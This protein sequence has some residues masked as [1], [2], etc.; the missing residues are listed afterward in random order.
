MA[1][2]V[3]ACRARV[4]PESGQG[5]ASGG[6][7]ADSAA[8][9]TVSAAL[10]P[11]AP[12]VEP[13]TDA[14]VPPVVR[15]SELE[16][17][18]PPDACPPTMAFLA[19]GD[20]WMG[21]PRGRRV[22]DEQ[23]RFS[24][25]VASFCLDTYEVTAASYAQCVERGECS[26]PHGSQS[27]CN[28]GR[29]ED[30]PVNCVDW[31][32]AAAYCKSQGSRLP[33]EL[34]WEY[35]ARGGT[36]YYPYAWGAE[37]PDQRACWKTNQT[38]PV[39]SYPPGAFGLR[40]LSGNVWEWTNDWYGEYPWPQLDGSAKVFRGGGWGRRRESSLSSTLRGRMHPRDWGSHLGFRCARLAQGAECPFGPGDAPGLCR[41][42]VLEAECASD[43]QRFNGQRCTSVGAA[44]CASGQELVSGHGCVP[45]AGAAAA[46]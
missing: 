9:A 1:S 30:H 13:A 12:S 19:G 26:V 32:Q 2:A 16:T 33:S 39:G 17:A 6:P 46:R 40:D 23:P 31:Q 28:Y 38:C 41:H 42:G 20:F 7:Q 29:R 4:E 21:S 45:R 36:R 44:A 27:S 3:A 11:D 37:P 22:S 34:E 35:A 5:G 8:L 43:S 18:A 15:V 14:A 24:T 10:R 25:R